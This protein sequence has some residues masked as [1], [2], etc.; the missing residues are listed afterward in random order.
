MSMRSCSRGTESITYSLIWA[1]R[2]S[3]ARPAGGSMGGARRPRVPRDRGS[4][5]Q[6]SRAITGE[7]EEIPKR[8]THPLASHRL[9]ISRSCRETP[10]PPASHSIATIAPARESSAPSSSARRR[11]DRVGL[12]GDDLHRNT[13]S[14]GRGI[15][16]ERHHRAEQQPPRQRPRVQQEQRGR[17]VGPVGEP[18]R[19]RRGIPYCRRAASTNSA[20]C[21]VRSRRSSRSKTPSASRR[22]KRGIPFSSTWPR[23]LNR[24]E[25]D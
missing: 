2:P 1:Y 3:L 9:P 6:C 16:H 23:G 10:C 12:T 17:D 11:H 8:I 24:A 7:R 22:K 25:P 20:S 5:Y 14:P 18:D 13:A 15:R 21:P 19:D 4:F